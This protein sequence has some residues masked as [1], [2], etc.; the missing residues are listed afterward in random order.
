[1]SIL[2]GLTISSDERLV[3]LVRVFGRDFAGIVDLPD[4]E[5]LQLVRALEA[6][7]RFV[8]ERA[9]PGDSAG[10]IELTLEPTERGIRAAVHDWGRPLTSAEGPGDLIPLGPPVE[11]LRL[12]NLGANGKRLSFVWRTSH[13]TEFAAGV[14]DAPTPVMAPPDA[15][16]IAVRD[17]R[18]EDAEPIA[19]LLYENYAL[20]YVHPDFYRPRWLRDELA[21]GRVLSTVAEH[22]GEVIAHH[23]LLRSPGASAA[24]SGVA[25]VAPAYRGLGVFGRLS[26]H[27]LA[28]A[29]EIGLHA[30]YGRAVTVHPYS[31]R[32]EL[33]HGYRETAVCLAGSPGRTR[34]RGI[35]TATEPGR[36][37]AHMIAFLPLRRDPRRASLPERHRD[38]LLETYDRLG[39]DAPAPVERTTRA[40]GTI[41]VVHDREASV[42]VLS[43]GGWGDGLAAEAIRK[44]RMLLAEHVDVVYADLDLVATTDPDAAVEAL[45]DQGFSYAGLWLH[46]PGNHDHLRLQRLNSTEIELDAIATASPAGHELVRYV[47]ADLERVASDPGRPPGRSNRPLG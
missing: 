37:T 23:A 36:R 25:V 19:R 20:S 38:R 30:I 6:A 8:C 35:R 16:G 3:P 18:P 14:A 15:T 43:V 33:A 1:M 42:A 12:I 2:A 24:E 21:S 40:P 28:R 47:L 45:R 9:Y 22:G 29:R 44:I 31:Q 27:T 34:M 26:D 39:L 17:G 7:V 11:D 46:G 32:A 5:G 10:R 13:L 41:A 4:G